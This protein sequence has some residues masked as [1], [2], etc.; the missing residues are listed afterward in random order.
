M[1]ELLE[2]DVD[3]WRQQLPQMHEHFARL[4]DKLPGA[5]RDQLV[6]LEKRLGAG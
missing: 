4:G 5:L 3:G 2:V 1:E 6:A